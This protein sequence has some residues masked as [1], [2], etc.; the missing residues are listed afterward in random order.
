MVSLEGNPGLR[1]CV[2]KSIASFKPDYIAIEPPELIG[3]GVSVSKARPEIISKTVKIVRETNPKV[4]VLCCPST[5]CS[6]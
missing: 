2:M 3:T 4:K 1:K 5:P 6:R